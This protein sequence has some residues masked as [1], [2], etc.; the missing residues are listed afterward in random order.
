MLR[1]RIAIAFAATLVSASLAPAQ[2][3]LDAD[4]DSGSLCLFAST[5]CDDNGVASSVS[6]NIVTLV[7][8]DNFNAGNWK[9]VYF[10]ASGVAG[11]TV[12]F[13]IGDDFT[14]GSSNLNNHA[15]VYSY[16]QQTWHFF[17]NN[18]RQASLDRYSFSNNTAFTQEEVYVAYGLPYPASRV[19]DKVS[20][21]SASPYVAP[22][23]SGFGSM[24]IGQSPGGVDDIGRTIAGRSLYGFEITDATSTAAKQKIVLLGGTHANETVANWTLEGLVDF[25]VSDDLRAAQLRQRADFYV[26][27]MSNP[28]GRSAGMNRT[29][30]QE[31]GVDPNRVWD[32]ASNYNG[33]TD[34]RTVGQS[35]RF[36]TG[37]DIDYFVDFHSTVNKN[38]AP[39]HFGYLQG[40][41]SS[42]PFWQAVL[43]REPELITLGA[44]LVD[45]TGAKFGRDELGAEVSFTFETQFMPGENTDRYL[46]LGENF[47]LAWWD[48]LVD[49]GDFNFDGVIDAA[50]YL[51]LAANAETDLSGLSPLEAYAAGDLDGDGRNSIEDFL[52][53][54]GV[55]VSLH[56]AAAFAAIVQGVPEPSVFCSLSAIFVL[57]TVARP[58]AR[59]ET[60]GPPRSPRHPDLRR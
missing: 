37:G 9:W 30:V 15:M 17:D 45:F 28:D 59:P 24:V 14:T 3:T 26:Y 38:E 1:L 4:F 46:T 2:I 21:W 6:G 48:T 35:M 12:Q 27:P 36:D 34:I 23:G 18:Q 40:S 25:L 51:I 56:G 55:Y 49:H 50:D 52:Q 57:L 60:I 13:R 31:Q 5:A 22:L 44:S 47:G 16:D 33:Q 20:A 19:D 32:S 42:S 11:Q 41:M 7:G 43:D 10:R 39:Y 54:K 53:F 8:R 58:A 29:T